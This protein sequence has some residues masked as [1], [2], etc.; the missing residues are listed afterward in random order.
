MN[1]FFYNKA[2]T[3]WAL[4]HVSCVALH[5]KVIDLFP[6]LV[7]NFRGVATGDTRSKGLNR[8]CV[9]TRPSMGA[10]FVIGALTRQSLSAPRQVDSSSSCRP[11]YTHKTSNSLCKVISP[12]CLKRQ[13]RV[14]KIPF[15]YKTEVPLVS[16]RRANKAPFTRP[17]DFLMGML[18]RSHWNK[19]T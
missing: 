10:S 6:Y 13:T 16:F 9:T 5:T 17:L 11:G 2:T 1:Q 14:L 4:Q 15:S 8:L 19:L 3:A 7:C 18:K 12:H